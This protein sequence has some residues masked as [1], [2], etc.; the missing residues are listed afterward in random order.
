MVQHSLDLVDLTVSSHERHL[1]AGRVRSACSAAGLTVHSTFTG[2]AAYSSNLMLDPEGRRRAAAET[3]FRRVIDYTAK[4]GAAG[5][6][7]HVGAYGNDDWNDPARRARLEAGL[8]EALRRLAGAARRAGL[9]F[10]LIEN[11]AAA[12]E[13]ST[14]DGIERLLA[15]G[16]RHRVPVQLCLDV[17]HMCVHGTQGAER[18]PYA[19]L[20][21]FGPRAP[22]VHL[23]QS[24]ATGDHHW[25]FTPEKN[26]LG[27]I[28]PV[29]VLESLA[30]SGASDVALILEV[31]P[32]FEADD[33]TVLD[34]LEVSVA[35]WRRALDQFRGAN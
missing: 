7:G 8:K 13:P 34:D 35:Y 19:W 2:L 1:D 28:E 17:G 3:W 22:I 16:D 29:G 23:Q 27:R 9:D 26:R 24:D 12:R 31:I 21:R 30:A 14:M 20:R 5:A 15:Q 25:P 4:T 11:M 33:S 32:P 18:D 6:G 10:F